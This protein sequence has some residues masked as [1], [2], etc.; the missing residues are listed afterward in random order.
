METLWCDWKRSLQINEFRIKDKAEKFVKTC[1]SGILYLN[2]IVLF[3]LQKVAPKLF[4]DLYA[5]I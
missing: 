1:R 5:W 4:R 2:S 3:N